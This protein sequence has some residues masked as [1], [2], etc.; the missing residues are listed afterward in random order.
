[1]K[2]ESDPS[3]CIVREC[4]RPGVEKIDLAVQV[5]Y[6]FERSEVVQFGA[7]FCRD[8]AEFIRRGQLRGLSIGD[9]AKPL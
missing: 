2:A 9:P 7:W 5:N 6:M 3:T 8:H 1:M 4:D